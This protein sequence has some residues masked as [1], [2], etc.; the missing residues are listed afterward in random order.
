L[1]RVIV[2]PGDLHSTNASV[3]PSSSY[4]CRSAG[5]TSAAC[6]IIA[7]A[8]FSAIWVLGV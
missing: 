2:L 5:R 6:S 8:V 4:F 1:C 7:Y 3:F